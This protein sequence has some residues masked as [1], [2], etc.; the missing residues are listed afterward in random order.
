MDIQTNTSAEPKP[1]GRPKGFDGT[2]SKMPT[3]LAMAFKKAGLDWKLDFAEA[4]KNNKRER[5]KLWLKLLPY[6]ITTS[7]RAKIKRWT[8]RPSKAA[9]IALE[10]MERDE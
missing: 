8:G 10:A 5:I 1:V 2:R 4:I 3:A 6:M 7:R 9:L